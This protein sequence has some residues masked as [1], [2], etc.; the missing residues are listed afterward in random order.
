MEV[1]IYDLLVKLPKR[2]RRRSIGFIYMI[3]QNIHYD[4][5]IFKIHIT[6]I[7]KHLPSYNIILIGA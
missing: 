1:P 6:F 5:N 4:L 3:S 2:S 7:L